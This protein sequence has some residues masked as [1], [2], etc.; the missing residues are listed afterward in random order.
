[1][2]KITNLI[3]ILFTLIA[4]GMAVLCLYHIF[5]KK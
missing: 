4:A 5:L 3:G 2:K 1:M